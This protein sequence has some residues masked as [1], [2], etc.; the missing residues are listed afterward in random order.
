MRLP[1]HGPGAEPWRSFVAA[2]PRATF[3]HGPAWL[4]AVEKGL[5][6]EAVIL[7]HC[8]PDGA[9]RGVLPLALCRGFAGRALVGSPFRDQGGPLVLDPADAAPLLDEALDL[10]RALRVGRVTLNR[11]DEALADV[12]AGRGFAPDPYGVDCWLEFDQAEEAYVSSLKGS[13]RWAVRKAHNAGLAVRADLAGERLDAFSALFA[14]TRQRLGVA[15]YPAGFLRRLFAGGPG[16]AVLLAALRPDGGL[17]GG[18]VVFRH[19]EQA[20]S[21]YLA[22]AYEHRELRIADLLFHEAIRWS[23][24]SG[25]RRFLFGTDSPHQE[26]LIAYKRKWLA[27]PRE[28]VAWHWTADGRA[29]ARQDTEAGGFGLVRTALRVA[30]RPLF[31]L[32]SRLALGFWE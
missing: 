31:L 25:A 26:S 32:A 29:Y 21:G 16:K 14:A 30:P 8:G 28:A 9:V 11:P 17:A 18:L 23:R 2:H 19:G 10:A 5:G 27:E 7:A 22:Y 20:F 4:D 6:K 15:A 1:L 13:V 12:L 24:E 3:F